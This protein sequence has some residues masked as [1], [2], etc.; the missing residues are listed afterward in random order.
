M[1]NI[2]VSSIAGLIVFSCIVSCTRD[3]VCTDV[4]TEEIVSTFK[5][6]PYSLGG[7]TNAYQSCEANTVVY[8]NP[9]TDEQ[10]GKV[11]KL[12]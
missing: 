5:S 2:T 3:C 6:E 12:H 11:C 4:N 1:K 10:T 9:N 7:W 8:Y